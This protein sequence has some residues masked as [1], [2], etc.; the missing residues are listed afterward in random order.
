MTFLPRAGLFPRLS[1]SVFLI[2]FLSSCGDGDPTAPADQVTARIVAGAQ[3][4]GTAGR[5]LPEPLVVEVLNRDGDPLAGQPVHWSTSDGGSLEPSVSTTGADG[6]ASARW[7]LGPE[8]GT[9]RV[10]VEIDG[11]A[12]LTIEATARTSS[13]ASIEPASD[14][15][16]SG[17]SGEPLTESLAVRLLDDRGAPV[18][19]EEVRW[20]APLG[21]GSVDPA[22]SITD[23]DGIARAVWTLGL[24]A[25]AQRAE[26]SAGELARVAFTADSR[27]PVGRS[28]GTVRDV[29]GVLA[30]EIP[31]LALDGE[32]EFT[33]MPADEAPAD[34]GLVAGTAH[35]LGPDGLVFHRPATLTIAFDPSA[36][37]SDIEAS[38]LAVH[39]FEDGVWAER[40]GSALNDDGVSVS[41]QLDGLSTYALL[42]RRPVATVA[43]EPEEA[44]LAALGEQILFRALLRDENGKPL[45]RATRDVT[46]TSDD[47]RVAVVDADGV[48]T[49]LEAGTA[50]ITATAGSHSGSATLRVEPVPV[51]LRV[52]PTTLVIPSVGAT[53]ELHARAVDALGNEFAIDGISWTSDDPAIASVAN[54]VVTAVAPGTTTV[55]A[56]LGDF[57]AEVEVEVE[58]GG[59]ATNVTREA[60]DGQRVNI[61]SAAPVPPA[62]RVTDFRGD[63][64]AGVAVTFA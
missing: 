47:T 33:M 55:R 58:T 16:R 1:F 37:P 60:G 29:H 25:G 21:Q 57:R 49:A 10:T 63:P 8:V 13:A 22:T 48:V 3:Q 34:P 17:R 12:P 15:L 61:G 24:T 18:V 53:R 38:D 39:R 62:V 9:Q 52:T 14:T 50:R 64:V 32:Y 36:L 19:G 4:E 11:L 35:D 27:F 20:A 40:F 23:V 31:A 44:A 59:I 54:G 56:R 28:G 7:T 6:R 5:E 26:A 45:D 42:D 46:W 43:V 41:A 2:V 51:T 30:L